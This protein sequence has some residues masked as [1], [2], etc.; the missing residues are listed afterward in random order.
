M[1]AGQKVLIHAGSGGVGT[2]AIQLAKHLGAY[3]ATTASQKN[4]DWL[5]SLGADEVIDYKTQDF[6]EI[7]SDY[8]V[9][10]DTQGGDTL[11]KS[12]KSL[13]DGGQI[14]SLAGPPNPEFAR[15]FGASWLVKTASYVL[16]Y[17]IRQAVA[18]KTPVINLSL[19]TPMAN[20]LSN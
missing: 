16:S 3:V 18:K 17:R 19:C 6:S 11:T 7:L 15:A 12:V 5:K 20:N 8:D 10:L 1:K 13:K 9:I 4:A 14:I 2:I